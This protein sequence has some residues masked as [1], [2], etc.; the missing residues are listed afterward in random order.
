[1]YFYL[2]KFYTWSAISRNIATSI[3]LINKFYIHVFLHQN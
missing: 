1:M 3:N 2:N